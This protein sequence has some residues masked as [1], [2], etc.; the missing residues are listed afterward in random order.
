M[1]RDATK[2]DFN[3]VALLQIASWRS[4][5]KDLLPKDYL[6]Q[7]VADDLLQH[8][9]DHIPGPE[10]VILVHQGKNGIDGFIN[11]LANTPAYIDNLH[12]DPAEKSL[13]IGTT[14]MRAAATRLIDLEQSSARL[15]VITGNHSA[16]RFYQGLGARRGVEKQVL[17]YGQLVTSVE[18]IWADLW[19][20]SGRT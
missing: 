12:V 16:I 7:P 15:T 8:W 10:D 5:Y 2:A 18:M 4:A 9:S 6:G 11:V 3:A 1:I 13:G 14:L 20:L 17:L 19:A